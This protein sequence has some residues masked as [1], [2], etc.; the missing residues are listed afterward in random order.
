[1]ITNLILLPADSETPLRWLR[2]DQRGVIIGRGD[3]APPRDSETPREAAARTVAV[4]PGD[5]VAI[6]WFDLPPLAPAQAQA[7]ARMMA[8][9]VSA[10]PLDRVHIALGARSLSGTAPL[11]LVDREAMFGWLA[12]LAAAGIDADHLVPAPMLLEA[13]ETG[14]NVLDAGALWLVRGERLAFAAEPEL[15]GMMIGDAAVH[16]VAETDWAAGVLAPLTLD[17]RQGEFARLRRRPVDRAQMR[18]MAWLAAGI[19][20]A[21]VGNSVAGLARYSF[22]ADRAEMALADAARQALP[23]GT[24][25]RE[26]RA[27]VAARLAQLGGDGRDFSGLVAPLLAAMRDRPGTALDSLRYAPG[28]GLAAVIAAPAAADRDAVVA[29]ITAAGFDARIGN[30]REDGGRQL[31]DLTVAPR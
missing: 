6:H 15:A 31:S 4:V 2:I 23:R 14:V 20:A 24:V 10:S 25:V 11:A 22:A 18:R 5:A 3:G 9:D 17:L 7:A 16:G 28:T 1:M 12:T 8:A 29:A 21:L 30:P 19:A 13:P 27:Q 26:P